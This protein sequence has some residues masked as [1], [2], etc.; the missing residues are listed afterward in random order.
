MELKAVSAN[1]LL[2]EL[3]FG[4][5][6]TSQA[7]DFENDSVG[8]FIISTIRNMYACSDN[9][10]FERTV[11]MR[12]LNHIKF[13]VPLQDQEHRLSELIKDAHDLLEDIGEIVQVDSEDS[14]RRFRSQIS[15]YVLL[16]ATTRD[17][18]TKAL[19]LGPCWSLQG[20]NLPPGVVLENETGLRYL[21]GNQEDLESFLQSISIY[22]IPFEQ[23]RGYPPLLTPSELVNILMTKL[24]ASRDT[25]RSD[26]LKIIDKGHQKYFKSRI[27]LPKA[28]DNGIF[29]VRKS[30]EYGA[31][32][33]LVG[34]FQNGVCRKLVS[35]P[36]EEITNNERDCERLIVTALDLEVG[37]PSRISVSG[38]LKYRN[39]FDFTFVNFFVPP[40]SWVKKMLLGYG[41]VLPKPKE[42]A[43]TTYA[44][45]WELKDTI[46][47]QV[48]RDMFSQ[49]N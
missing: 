28:T 33:S 30:A 22:S 29:A 26:D 9:G 6:Q 13:F 11:K 37:A 20:S 43:L 35:L 3:G 41:Y 15:M 45:P 39:F 24:L 42:G 1:Q 46:V 47:N 19:L 18:L 25:R 10:V 5:A 12:T 23:W 2:L 4:S 8:K 36:I 48:A 16:P 7:I 44:V 38:P 49:V 34:L 17:K 27:R 21:R 14:L 32:V 40:V 31:E